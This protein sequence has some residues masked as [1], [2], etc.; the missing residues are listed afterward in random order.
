[1]SHP[2]RLPFGLDGGEWIRGRLG[3]GLVAAFGGGI[4]GGG[5]RAEETSGTAQSEG[6]GGA[7]EDHGECGGF[8]S[9]D[10]CLWPMAC[11]DDG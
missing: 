9:H 11:F 2:I 1:M 4:C 3:G 6:G 8:Y 5:E 10:L 7:E